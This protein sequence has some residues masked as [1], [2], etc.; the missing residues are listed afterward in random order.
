MIIPNVPLAAYLLRSVRNVPI[1]SNFSR[2]GQRNHWGG[3][4][5]AHRFTW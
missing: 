5:M 2:A 1:D 3:L 4:H